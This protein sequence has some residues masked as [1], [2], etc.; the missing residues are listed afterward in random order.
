MAGKS[1]RYL[2]LS[3]ASPCPGLCPSAGRFTR[4]RRLPTFTSWALPVKVDTATSQKAPLRPLG[5]GQS[6]L[7]P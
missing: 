6:R 2:E 5:R 7:K 3:V 4:N 1:Q